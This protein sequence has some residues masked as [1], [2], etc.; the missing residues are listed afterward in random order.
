MDEK[1]IAQFWLKID[2]RGPEECWP[3]TA[4]LHRTGY[5]HTKF[6]G[7]YWLSH[8]AAYLLHYG[9]LRADL[10]VLHSCDN[11]A[12]CNPGHL[13]QGTAAQN[14]AEMASR[15]RSKNG[16]QPGTP[17]R[18]LTWEAVCSI[19]SEHAAGGSSVRG[20][21]KKHGVATKTIRDILQGKN[22]LREPPLPAL[23]QP[24]VDYA[25]DA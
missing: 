18:K 12:C 1:R 20:I 15:G 13:Y 14:M 21:A 8:R 16:S 17:R 9:R 11:P 4:S 5:G 2:R 19:R 10:H 7:K 6:E 23:P 25:W 24:R 22:W 3:W